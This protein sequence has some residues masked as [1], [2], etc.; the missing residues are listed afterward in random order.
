MPDATGRF[1]GEAQP[2]SLFHRAFSHQKPRRA[3]HE[4]VFRRRQ[5]RGKGP[6][7]GKR[8]IA[9]GFDRQLVAVVGEGNQTVEQMEPI[10]APPD[11]M[12]EQIDLR[13]CTQADDAGTCAQ[14]ALSSSLLGRIIAQAAVEFSLQRRDTLLFRLET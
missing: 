7:D 8:Q 1:F 14:R 6:I 9:G 4:I 12:Q 10:G 13:R 5:P 3:E 11:Q 2:G